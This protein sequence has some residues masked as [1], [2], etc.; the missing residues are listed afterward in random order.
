MIASAHV[1]AGAVV[2]ALAMRMRASV[3]VRVVVAMVAGVALHLAMDAVPH[4]D[5]AF[6]EIR[7]VPWVGLAEAAVACA[8]VT[9]L[10]KGRIGSSQPIVLFAAIASSMAP[11]V[12]FVARVLAPRYEAAITRITDTIHGLH[13]TQP[14]HVVLVFSG[15]VLLALGFFYVFWRMIRAGVAPTRGPGTAGAVPPS[16]S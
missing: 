14:L 13:A 7:W 5:Y 10:A 9:G 2:G 4:S 11:D 6:I 1:A 3:V 16:A 8:I 15:E 12:K